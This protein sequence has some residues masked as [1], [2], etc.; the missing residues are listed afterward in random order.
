MEVTSSSRAWHIRLFIYDSCVHF[1]INSAISFVTFLCAFSH[2]CPYAMLWPY[3]EETA[4]GFLNLNVLPFFCTSA[5][6]KSLSLYF[7]FLCLMFQEPAQLLFPW[8]SL[9]KQ[10]STP[11]LILPCNSVSE[12]ILTLGTLLM[13][14]TCNMFITCKYMI[15]YLQ[16]CPWWDCQLSDG[17]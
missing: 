2:F 1:G 9:P 12:C 14:C 15:I 6:A 4:G 10:L 7:L 5:H 3:P 16:V 8:G 13:W 17:M 11:S